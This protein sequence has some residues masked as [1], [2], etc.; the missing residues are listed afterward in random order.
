MCGSCSLSATAHL[1][2]RHNLSCLCLRRTVLAGKKRRGEENES[3]PW[4]KELLITL[5]NRLAP[6]PSQPQ[7]CIFLSWC[8]TTAKRYTWAHGTGHIQTQ[9]WR[10]TPAVPARSGVQGQSQQHREFESSLD[11][12]KPYLKTTNIKH[13]TKPPK[14]GYSV[15]Y[16]LRSL[17][18][19]VKGTHKTG[20]FHA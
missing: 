7:I 18:A 16:C 12:T 17:Q 15:N 19:S 14:Y 10:G 6:S 9:A 4:L 8:D 5:D 11:Y 3:H 2:D 1:V 20:E 13:K